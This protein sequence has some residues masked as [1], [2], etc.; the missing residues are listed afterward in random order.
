[1]ALSPRMDSSSA[2][3]KAS[4]ERVPSAI[5]LISSLVPKSDPWVE[6]YDSGVGTTQSTS[7]SITT[8]PNPAAVLYPRKRRGID[9]ATSQTL[10]VPAVPVA[11]SLEWVMGRSG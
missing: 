10:F 2:A 6:E 11:A 7:Q 9:K 3:F 4:R 1:M 5:V 8:R